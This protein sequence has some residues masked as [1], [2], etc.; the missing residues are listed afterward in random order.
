MVS[1]LEEQTTI[2]LRLEHFKLQQNQYITWHG[3]HNRSATLWWYKPLFKI[4][5]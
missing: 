2:D 5:E 1:G 3:L 4:L